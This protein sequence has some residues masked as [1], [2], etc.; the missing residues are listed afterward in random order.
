MVAVLV[1]SLGCQPAPAEVTTLGDGPSSGDPLP[2]STGASATASDGSASAGTSVTSGGTGGSAGSGDASSDSASGDSS[3]GEP[4]DVPLGPFGAP[5]AVV[6]LNAPGNED[7]PSLT[8]DMLEIYFNSNRNSFNDDIFVSTRGSVD[9][10]W[11]MPEPVGVVN[12][13]ATETFP[14][15]SLDGLVLLFASDRVVPTDLDVYYSWRTDRSQ[16]WSA[17]MPLTG[18]ANAGL[19]DY[20]ATPTPDMTRV[21]LCRDM[22]GGFGQSD[23]WEASADFTSWVVGEPMHVEALASP[24]ADCSSTLSPSERE[25][26]FETTR[27]TGL[28]WSIHTATRE[29]PTEP[30]GAP[31]AVAELETGFDEVDPWLSPDR[32]TLWFARGTVGAY[33]LYVAT[34]R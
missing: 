18:A 1:L 11:E 31:S 22:A 14:E 24:V 20:G 34:R 17:P 29:D 7:D 15:V 13:N 8:G 26:F 32:R 30:W 2:A 33:D 19:V 27:P 16:P 10:S 4:M 6:E 3:T 5:V 12:S 23:I 25:I 28:S 9:D 21:L